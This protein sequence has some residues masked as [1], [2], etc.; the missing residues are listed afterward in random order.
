MDSDRVSIQPRWVLSPR[1]VEREITRLN[2]A[3]AVHRPVKLDTAVDGVCD[4]VVKSIV[5]L[6]E[7]LKGG[8]MSRAKEALAK[9]VGKLVLTPVEHD[10]HLVYKVSGS[11]SVQPPDTGKCR[12]QLVARDGYPQHSTLVSIPLTDVFLDPKLDL[13]GRTVCVDHPSKE[14]HQRRFPWRQKAFENAGR[15]WQGRHRWEACRKTRLPVPPCEP[16]GDTE[17]EVQEVPS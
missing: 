13:S 6:A 1:E 11:V 14:T 5:R 16:S 15:Q 10:E 2:E 12:L 17:P 9:Q 7:M 3:I 4:H 8:D